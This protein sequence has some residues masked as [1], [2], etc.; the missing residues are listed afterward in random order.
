MRTFVTFSRR[1]LYKATPNKFLDS[2]PNFE[3]K[4]GGLEFFLFHYYSDC[5][6]EQNDT[7]RNLL[8]FFAKMLARKMHQTFS[9]FFQTFFSLKLGWK[10]F[11]FR[12]TFHPIFFLFAY[13]RKY[14]LCTVFMPSDIVKLLYPHGLHSLLE[15]LI[16]HILIS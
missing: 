6:K 13:I 11:F 7:E 15:F 14:M 3:K 8:F 12:K 1:Q 16:N 4:C 10:G 9:A 2:H 5:F